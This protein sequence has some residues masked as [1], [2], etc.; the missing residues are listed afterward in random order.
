MDIGVPTGTTVR[1]AMAGRVI[2][3]SYSDVYGY[4]IVISHHSGYRTLYGHL[5]SML[6]K[7]GAYVGTSQIIARSG[8][9]GLS[10]G[11]HLHFTVYKNGIT[12]NPRVLMN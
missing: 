11:P 9:T 6:V 1:A 5:S 8:S 4:Y 3:A 12:T 10:T 2:T 7:P